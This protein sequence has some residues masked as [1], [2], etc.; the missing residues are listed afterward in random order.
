MLRS[1]QLFATL[2]TVA[3][4]APLPRGFSRQ[5]YWSGFHFL[6]QRRASLLAQMIKNPPAMQDIQVPPLGQEDVLEKGMATHS[7]LLAWEILRTEESAG[8]QPMGLQRVRHD[9]ATHTFTLSIHFLQGLFPNPGIKPISPKSPALAGGF[10]TTEPLGRLS[11]NYV[12]WL[13]ASAYL[14]SSKP[15]HSSES[16]H[17]AKVPEFQPSGVK[18]NSW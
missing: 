10:F 3:C 17:S 9:W 16:N 13:L 4:Q 14:N 5:E 15:A 2:W 7:S 8:L 6:L 11:G 12:P 18:S 1:I